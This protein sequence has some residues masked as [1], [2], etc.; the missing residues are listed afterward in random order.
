LFAEKP[1]DMEWKVGEDLAI[2][3]NTGSQARVNKPTQT[4]VGQTKPK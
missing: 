4:H 2:L 3:N 1:L